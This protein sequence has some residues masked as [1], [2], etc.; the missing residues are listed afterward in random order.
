MQI[1][2]EELELESIKTRRFIEGRDRG[3]EAAMNLIIDALESDKS[4]SV[5][6]EELK[7]LNAKALKLLFVARNSLDRN[8]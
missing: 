3:Y 1:I 2:L 5:N 7:P 4:I 8:K 6:F